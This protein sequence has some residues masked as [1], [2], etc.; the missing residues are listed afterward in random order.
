MEQRWDAVPFFNDTGEVVPA[1]ALLEPTGALTA[2]RVMKVRKPTRNSGGGMFVNGRVRVLAGKYGQ[3]QPGTPGALLRVSPSD[4]ITAADT[5]GSKSG[6]WYARK[7][8]AG[9]RPIG[10]AYSGF[11]PAVAD[12]GGGGPSGGPQLVVQPTAA[13]NGSQWTPGLVLRFTGTGDHAPATPFETVD[14]KPLH[15]G[16][17][18]VTGQPYL[19]V[20]TGARSSSGRRRLRTERLGGAGSPAG[21]REIT[22]VTFV[23]CV[24]DAV[25]PTYDRAY[26]PPATP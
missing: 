7:G 14:L 12:G 20:D 22:V 24:G 2:D 9:F 8:F 25:H 23:S 4:T 19:A 13:N 16:D 1:G 17:T 11:V 6:D 5:L 10:P 15:P 3:C 26:A 21:S 18:L